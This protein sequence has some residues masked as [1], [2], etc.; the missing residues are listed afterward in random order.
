MERCPCHRVPRDPLSVAPS[1]GGCLP[2][3][4]SESK[5][6][7]QLRRTPSASLAAENVVRRVRQP[8][9]ERA[10]AAAILLSRR[11]SA[12]GSYAGKSIP[13]DPVWPVKWLPETLADRNE[14]HSHSEAL[15]KFV[16][17]NMSRTQLLRSGSLY[18]GSVRGPTSL[19]LLW[20]RRP[21]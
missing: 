10:I 19:S 2:C 6:G 13:T 16:T 15:I 9:F 18:R 1:L 3:P 14:L 21:S 4:G 20:F 5:P 7:E 8:P 12:S 11:E 17:P